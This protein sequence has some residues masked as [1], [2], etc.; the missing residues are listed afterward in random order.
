MAKLGITFV[1]VQEQVRVEL[2]LGQQRR[3]LLTLATEEGVGELAV[4]QTA[5][6]LCELFNSTGEK[7]D[8]IVASLPVGNP[9]VR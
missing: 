9:S 3:A 8:A 6:A 1:T 5:Q 4:M 7:P 2:Q